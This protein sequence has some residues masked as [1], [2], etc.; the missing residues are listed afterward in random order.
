M[1]GNT[2]TSVGKTE[3]VISQW[4]AFIDRIRARGLPI[5]RTFGDSAEQLIIKSINGSGVRYLMEN[6]M[7]RPVIDRIRLFD[8]LFA[9][10]RATILKGCTKT[11]EAIENA[12][13]NEKIGKDE[14]LD[15][16]TSNID[17]LDAMEY[18][19][20]RDAAQLVEFIR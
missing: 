16:G 7:K 4:K 1:K 12:V 13:Y 2:P 11:I 20:E 17:S 15:D 14:R 5:D 19:V 8:V 18:A 10:G 9:T 3:S 6:A